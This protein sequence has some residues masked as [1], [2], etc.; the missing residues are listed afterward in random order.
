MKRQINSR[1]YAGQFTGTGPV[2]EDPFGPST[3]ANFV[4]ATDKQVGFYVRLCAERGVNTD[5]IDFTKISKSEI[6]KAIDAILATPKPT[7]PE[8]KIEIEDGMYRLD[9]VI[10]K[11]QHAVHGSGRQYAKELVQY[12]DGSWGFEFARGMVYKLRPEHKMTIEEAKE[13]GALYGTCCVCGRTLTDEK[14]IEAGIGPICAS[15]F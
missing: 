9:D 3:P 13:F 4:P 10:Y 12:A 14:S 11:V 6:S 15:K 2:D 8:T 7:R 5:M 1:T